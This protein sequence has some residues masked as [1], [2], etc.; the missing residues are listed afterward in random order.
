V[1][2]TLS[3]RNGQNTGIVEVVEDMEVLTEPPDASPTQAP[4][5]PSTG[6]PLF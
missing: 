5:A 4:Q 2:S 3:T 6:H 1:D